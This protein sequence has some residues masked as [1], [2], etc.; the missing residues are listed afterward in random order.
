MPTFNLCLLLTMKN[1]GDILM[2]FL[3]KFPPKF[4]NPI[5]DDAENRKGH[6]FAKIKASL[7]K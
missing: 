3:N 5:K 2:L 7:V 1:L 4:M 6:L